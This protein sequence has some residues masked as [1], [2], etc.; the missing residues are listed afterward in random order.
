MEFKGS[1]IDGVK[2]INPE[3]L[4]DERGYFYESFR[5]KEYA[6][7]IVLQENVS[8]N[9]K[10]NTFR[11]LHL[12]NGFKAQSKLISCTKGAM[13]DFIVDLRPKS[14]SYLSWMI[15]KLDSPG[16]KMLLVPKGCAHGYLTLEDKTEVV[17]K[18][19]N[20][21]FPESE[22][23]LNVLDK[24]IGFTHEFDADIIMSTRD[25]KGLSLEETIELFIAPVE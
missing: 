11:G 2:F 21:Y 20:Y 15:V 24:N 17:Y 13:L 6:S 7:F 9:Y 5:S 23:I 3:I 1:L 4:H 8:F 25:S 19:D 22:L 18:V 14:K 12:Q 16:R 10:R